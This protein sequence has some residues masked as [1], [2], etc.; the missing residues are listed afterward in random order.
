MMLINNNNWLN[1]EKNKPGQNGMQ[2]NLCN[3]YKDLTRKVE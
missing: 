2:T 3:G 1:L